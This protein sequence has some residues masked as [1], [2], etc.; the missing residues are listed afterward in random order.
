MID[1]KERTI[2]EYEIVRKALEKLNYISDEYIKD[3]LA[4]FVLDENDHCIG[5]LTDGDIRRHL[6]N[7]HTIEEPVSQFMNSQFHYLSDSYFSM[8]DVQSL[9]NLNYKLVPVIDAEN[10]ILKIIDFTKKKSILP[11]DAVIMAGGEGTRL[12]PLTNNIPKPL[13]KV[14][15]KPIIEYNVDR[16]EKYGIDHIILS[17]RYLGEQLVEYFGDGSE[18]DIEIDY[19]FENQPLGTMGALGLIDHFEHD[20]VLL[21]NS[22]LLTTID[23]AHFFDEFVSKDIDMA[24]ASVPY[25]VKLPYAVLQM[26]GEK[27]I[28]CKEKPEYTYYSNAGIYLLKR[29][30][31][32]RIPFN[33]RVDVTDFIAD[34]IADGGKVNY[35]PILGYWLDIGKMDDFKQAQKDIKLLEL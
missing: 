13:L 7:G 34:L 20:Y 26:N 5:S 3:P 8:Q 30:L 9:Y 22:D 1:L 10:H 15:D 11:I 27:I 23:Y 35:Y 21:M 4:L 32:N 12:R 16:L 6:L 29:E 14:G 31:I 18:R 24:V 33:K 17:V 25:E 28:E 19:I 2:Y